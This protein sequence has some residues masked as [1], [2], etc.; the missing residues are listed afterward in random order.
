MLLTKASI[1][2]VANVVREHGSDAWF[3]LEPADL[4]AKY[5]AAADTDLPAWA[6][7]EISNLKSQIKKAP[8]IFDVWFESGS[9][10]NAVMVQRGL[11]H[12][13]AKQPVTDLYLEGS[14]QHRGWFQSSLIP[15]LGVTGRS[16]F[17]T[18]LT[19]GFMVD[20]DGKKMSKSLGNT[21]EV[22][23]LLKE[24]GADVCRWWVCSLNTDNDIKVDKSYFAL[25]GEEYRKVRNTI[26]FLLSNLYDFQKPTQTSGGHA[27]VAADATSIDAWVMNELNELI[28]RVK[29]AYDDYDFKDAREAIFHFCNETLSAIYLAATKDRL[30][31]DKPDSA[32]RRRTQTAMHEIT[33]TLILL[34]APVLPHTADEAWAALH[35]RDIKESPSVHLELFPEAAKAQGGAWSDVFDQRDD[36]LK[37]IEESRQK[38]EIDNPLDCGLEIPASDALKAFAAGDLAD[39]CGISRVKLVEGGELKLIDLRGEPRCE[40]S[41]KRD[42]TVKMRSDGSELSDRD[43][44]ALGLV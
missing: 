27:W 21:V 16:P 10:W 15:A 23:D 37:V 33:R 20:K 3:K 41:W 22:E 4:L 6:Q 43:A 35:Q 8:D 40:R 42:G 24:Y 2:A 29:K 34:I 13:P 25:A 30:Y 17:A 7:S 31:C 18:V 44:L 28:A 12:D 14:D 9:S 11:A 19:H 32:R 5:D 1:L 38:L 26:R 36:W 39:L